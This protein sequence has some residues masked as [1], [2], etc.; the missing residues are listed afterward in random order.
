MILPYLDESNLYYHFLKFIEITEQ[1]LNISDHTKIHVQASL[2]A[3]V[4]T[5]RIGTSISDDGTYSSVYGVSC[6]NSLK[7][8]VIVL[9]YNEKHRK[10]EETDDQILINDL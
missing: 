5:R 9:K 10:L 3:T 8:I 4:T 2:D 6:Q 1:Y 7:K